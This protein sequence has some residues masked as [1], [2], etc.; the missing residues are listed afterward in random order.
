MPKLL[1]HLRSFMTNIP[2][3]W[4]LAP[5]LGL[6]PIGIIGLV[7]YLSCWSGQEVVTDLAHPLI[8]K[9][10]VAASTRNPPY[11]AITTGPLHQFQPLQTDNSQDSLTRSFSG[12]LRDRSGQLHQANR[13]QSLTPCNSKLHSVSFISHQEPYALTWQIVTVAPEPYFIQ[14]NQDTNRHKI[15]LREI[16]L[17]ETVLFCLLIMGGI[18]VLRLFAAKRLTTA[19]A[20]LHFAQLHRV[21]RKLVAGA[22]S[23]QLPTDRSKIDHLDHSNLSDRQATELALQRS[24]ARYRAIVEDQTDLIARCLPDTTLVFVNHAYCRYFGLNRE[25][26]IGKSY[27]PTIHAADRDRVIQLVQS[28]SPD[29]PMVTSENRV[30][31]NGEIRWTQ[32]INRLLFDQQGNVIEIQSVGRDITQLKQIETALRKS[33][34]KLSDVLSNTGASI[35]S[36]RLF[37]DRSWKYEYWSEGCEL[38]FGYTAQE[39]LTNS[40]LWFS[41]VFPEDIEQGRV[42]KL[43]SLMVNY[44]TTTEGEYRFFHQDGTLRWSSFRA[45]SRPDSASGWMVTVIDVDIT[46][47]KQ[48]EQALQ[49][50]E[51][52]LRAI[53]DNLP[54]GFIYQRVYEPGKGSYYSYVSAGVERLL[55]LKPEAI[56]ADPKV[57][58]TI[59]FEEDLAHADRVAQESLQNL[60]PIELQMR[61]RAHPGEVRWSS[62]RST[63]RR[64]EDGRTVWDGVEVDIT[65][66]KRA[67]AALRTSEEQ[68]RR[69]FDD[70]PIGVSLVLLTGQ[71]VKV[72]AC[73]CDLLGYTEAE[74][75]SLTFQEI[76]HPADLAA[77]LAGV[78]R[79]LAGEIRS[80]QLEKRYITKQGEIIPVLMNA[81][82]I[83]DQN[84]QPLYSVGHIQDIRDRLKIERMKHEFISVISHELRTPLTSIQGALDLLTSGI[85][86]NRPQK[87]EHMLNIAVNNSD[88]LVRLVNHIL[89]LE[90]LESGKVQ[91]VMEQCQ[92][93]NLMQQAIEGIQTIAD[94]AG[95]TLCCTAIPVTLWAAPDAILQALTNVLGNAIKFSSPGDTVWLKA[96]VLGPEAWGQESTESQFIALA[97]SLPRFS[98]VSPHLLLIIKDQGRG[99]PADKLELIF[100][101]FQQVDLS[102]SSKKGGTGLGLAICKNIVQ[103]HGGQIWVESVLGKGSTFYIALPLVNRDLDNGPFSDLNRVQ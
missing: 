25:D 72:N 63:P 91:L 24:E 84:G 89:A 41:R 46:E 28:M 33:E 13:P 54:K 58:R 73:Y 78:Q 53:G 45:T 31:V 50:R 44:P 103:Q 43:E 57:T 67:E 38:V 3:R 9:T 71:F 34:A 22:R 86:K 69:A 92:I 42:V 101:Q 15:S 79:M 102:D 66:L 68:F 51:A 62:I 96:E 27:S 82:L 55:G 74:L 21:S 37:P 26:I 59:G 36:F 4:L 19:L 10:L 7:G 30:V 76:T 100:E 70:A 35:A 14:A 52:M 32:W 2:L 6:T 18:A 20:Q 17:R 39:L 40:T 98:P 77:D 95:I 60:T 99:I 56:L 49:E 61:N 97:S 93:D 47:R 80:F 65:D 23:Q 83:R 94:Q 81:A 29:N 85:Y 5:A 12:Y 11:P 16:P 48:L 90:R 88:R 75:L 1:K 8:V 64:L 87:A